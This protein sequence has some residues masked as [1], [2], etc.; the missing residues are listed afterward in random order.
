MIVDFLSKTTEAK[1]KW[2]NVFPE[3]KEK[4]FQHRIL[5]PAKIEEEIKIFSKEGKITELV[6]RR[7]SLKE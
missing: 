2:H 1:R 6:T 7:P 4:K 5:Y 3:V